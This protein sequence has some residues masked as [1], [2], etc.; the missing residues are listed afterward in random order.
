M[1]AT[2]DV[3][4]HPQVHLGLSKWLHHTLL[5]TKRQVDVWSLVCAADEA[6]LAKQ[7]RKPPA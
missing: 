4:K 1:N 5:F 3:M 2:G 6:A 7:Y